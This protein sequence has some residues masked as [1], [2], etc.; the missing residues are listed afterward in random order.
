MCTMTSSNGSIF[1]VTC[2][3]WRESTGHRWIPL[4]K[5]NDAELWLFIWTAPEQGVAQQ[6]RRWWFKTPSHSLWLYC[7][8]QWTGSSRL[9][10]II[11]W[12]NDEKC[13]WH[14]YGVHSPQQHSYKSLLWWMQN[15]PNMHTV[16][17]SQWIYVMCIHAF[18]SGL[19]NSSPPSAAYMRQW[20]RSA[21]V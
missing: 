12:I 13:V 11:I 9:H 4:T 15:V 3:L 6:W 1:R 17:D 5:A 20:I 10:G 2:L 7:N 14:Q 16:F 18:A 8:G 19:L 21:L